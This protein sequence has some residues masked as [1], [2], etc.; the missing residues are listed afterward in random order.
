ML[1][2]KQIIDLRK[3]DIGDIRRSHGPHSGSNLSGL[4]AEQRATWAQAIVDEYEWETNG[5]GFNKRIL[6]RERLGL[7]TRPRTAAESPQQ[8][9]P[10]YAREA[11]SDAVEGTTTNQHEES[12]LKT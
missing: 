9:A 6:Q 4:N 7:G 11:G 5:A 3:T 1:V 12:T 10:Q 2:V 8:V